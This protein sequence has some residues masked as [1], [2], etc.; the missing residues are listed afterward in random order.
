MACSK[1]ATASAPVRSSQRLWTSCCISWWSNR[2][3]ALS[4]LIRTITF[5]PGDIG[6]GSPVMSASGTTPG[7]ELNTYESCGV[8]LPQR[9]QAERVDREH[10]LVAVARDQRDRPLRERA[11]RLPQVHV[12]AAQL[13]GELADLVHDR[14]HGQLHRLRQREAAPVDQR[15]DQAVQ[16][17]RVG[18]VVADRHAEHARLGAQARDR[19]D[20]AVVAE[21]RERLHAHERRP[22]VRRVAVVAE[23]RDGLAARVAR[24]RRSSPAA[25]AARP[26]PCRRS[27]RPTARRRARRAAV[28]ISI[29]TSN[30]MRSRPSASGTSTPTCQKCGS[31]SRAVGPSAA[32]STRSSRSASTRRPLRCRIWRARC[33]T[34]SKSAAA[35]DEDVR[36]RE[37][38]IE[39]KARRVPA[40]CA[41]PPARSGAGCRP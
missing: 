2:R 34:C 8:D 15:L 13:L 1:P 21:D 9:A 14:R 20:L 39:R 38:G 6:L 28:S 18:G 12:E 40:V 16:V 5:S 17:L 35:R 3:A 30:R 31:S 32:L 19:V 11:H 7:S 4:R 33:F 10:V 22:G 26:S 23:Q 24:G 29:A 27:S 41:P 37:R 25:P 36:D